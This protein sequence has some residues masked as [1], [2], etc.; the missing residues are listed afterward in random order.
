MPRWWGGFAARFA[1]RQGVASE[2]LPSR[3]HPPTWRRMRFP[4]PAVH[5]RR[6]V[7]EPLAGI[8]PGGRHPVL[9]CTV[10]ELREP[11]PEE[12]GGVNSMPATEARALAE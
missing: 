12:Q 1:S 9:H 4:H 7:L 8:A 2:R 10:R 5:L 6:F 11:L 3:F